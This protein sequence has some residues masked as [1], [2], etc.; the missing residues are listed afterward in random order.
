MPAG[1]SGLPDEGLSLWLRDWKA[2]VAGMPWAGRRLIAC[3]DRSVAGHLDF[4]IHPD[5]QAVKVWMLRVS[6]A[7]KRRGMASLLMDALYAAHPTAWIN[8]GV[9]TPDG[10]L[11][12]NGYRE[13]AP[14]RNV[15]NRPPG[16]WASYFDA[17]EVASEKAEIVDLN[18]HLGLDGHQDAA[19]RYGERLE[20][21]ADRYLPAYRPSEAACLDPSAQPLHG[22]TR[23]FL[24][25]DLHAYVHDGHQDAAGRAAALLD[26]LG[27]GRLPRDTHWNT[28][29]QAAFEDAHHEELF[30]DAVPERPATHLVLTLRPPERAALPAWSALPSSVTFTGEADLSVE[31]TGLSWRPAHH[32]HHTHT[33]AFTPPVQAAFAPLPYTDRADEIR[34]AVDRFLREQASRALAPSPS[35]AVPPAGAQQQTAPV[36]P[37]LHGPSR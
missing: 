14:R 5:G 10:T 20:E 6:P 36:P 28:T 24:P 7:F 9:R 29:R 37:R 19:Y 27:P 33:A 1:E 23:L 8:H 35:S 4:H 15:H 12:W 25:P 26:H 17:V 3:V 34:A 21:E 30:Q 2:P 32:P 31:V 16:E 22:A 11:W 13:P 18:D